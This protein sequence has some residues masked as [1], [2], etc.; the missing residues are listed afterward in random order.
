MG[1]GFEFNILNIL[2]ICTIAICTSSLSELLSWLLLYRKEE[3]RLNKSNTY[4]YVDEIE[5]LNKK[6]EKLKN[7]HVIQAQNKSH[8]K[9]VSQTEGQLK[10]LNQQMTFQSIKSN[11][12]IGVVMIGV[13]NLVGTYFQGIVV[14]SLPF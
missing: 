6:L 13:I 4:P 2:M 3:Y 8:E 1:E 7:T 10:S 12:L 11:L 14:A 9:K 5:K